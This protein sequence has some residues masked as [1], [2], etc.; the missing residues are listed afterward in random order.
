[1]HACMQAGRQAGR[2]TI[3][4]P[5]SDQHTKP[6]HTTPYLT[7]ILP[8]HTKHQTRPEHTRPYPTT[9]GPTLPYP[10]TKQHATYFCRYLA[11]LHLTCP[12]LT[13]LESSARIRPSDFG[14]S[15]AVRDVS[16]RSTFQSRGPGK[17]HFTIVISRVPYM[18]PTIWGL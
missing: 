6:N 1:M 14:P 15:A 4:P 9:P 2:Q 8:Y 17:L 11:A 16:A 12:L 5:I 3:M 13:H 18:N 10:S 7:I